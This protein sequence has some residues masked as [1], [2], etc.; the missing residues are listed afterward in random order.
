MNKRPSLQFYP[1]D[2]LKD[3][4]LQICSM[5]TIGVWINLLCRMWEVK[6]E[7]II[8][9]KPS[10]I[11]L[12]IG[13]KK[14]EFNRFLREAVTH[15]FANVQENNGIVTIV[16]RRMNKAYIERE[17]AKKRMKKYRSKKSDANVTEDVTTHSSS[18]SSS[19]KNKPVLFPFPERNVVSANCL[20][21]TVIVQVLMTAIFAL[22]THPPKSGRS[23]DELR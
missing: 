15:S 23:T 2:W 22:D 9:G 8:K 4:D 17:K 14:S 13:A 16:C 6:E 21:C 20:L 3:P 10:D 7:G 18:S 1:A 12:L 19:S 11:A 5:N